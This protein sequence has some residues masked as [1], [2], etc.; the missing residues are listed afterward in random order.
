MSRRQTG[1]TFIE[2]AVTLAIMGVLAA[3]AV[4][5]V[6][7]VSQRSKERELRSA[8]NQI[9]EAIDAHRRATDQGRIPVK[10]GDSGYPKSLND[11]VEGVTDAKSPQ[12]QKIY[13]LRR[14]PRD[15]MHLDPTVAAADTWGKR[16]YASPPD[17]PQEGEDVFDVHSLASG[18]GINGVPYREW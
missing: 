13:F 18:K 5:M 15:P 12:R 6:E 10:I 2:L 7:L 3:V 11:L 9:R 17:A 16:S 4:P 8:L 1:F 14:L